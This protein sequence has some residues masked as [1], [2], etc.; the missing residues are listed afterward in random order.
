MYLTGTD[1]TFLHGATVNLC[2]LDVDKNY[3]D[4]TLWIPYTVGL[5][6]V[7]VGYAMF[8]PNFYSSFMRQVIVIVLSIGQNEYNRNIF[9]IYQL[10]HVLWVLKRTI[11]VPSAY[12]YFKTMKNDF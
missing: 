11:S 3:S 4:Q 12:S 7:F 9:L 8:L 5:V 6:A 10:K 2:V 1:F